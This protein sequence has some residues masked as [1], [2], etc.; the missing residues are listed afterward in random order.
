MTLCA[1]LNDSL[2]LFLYSS[3]LVMRKM[4]VRRVMYPVCK[5]VGLVVT[6]LAV[7]FQVKVLMTGDL[8]QLYTS[9]A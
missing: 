4:P 3:L 5:V 1:R 8:I 7:V 6:M 9:F 2:R